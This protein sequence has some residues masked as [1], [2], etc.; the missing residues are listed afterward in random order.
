M[1]R[2]L[3]HAGLVPSSA[4]MLAL[5]AAPV[6]AGAY[7]CMD[8]SGELTYQ[9]H[10]CA[11]EALGNAIEPDIEAPGGGLGKE[12]SIEAQLRSLSRERRSSRSEKDNRKSTSDKRADASKSS[13]QDAAKC[14]KARAEAARWRGEIRKGYRNEDDKERK[15]QMLEYQEALAKRYCAPAP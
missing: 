11:G 2:S 14:A 13:G 10:P 4:L 1:K 5:V 8:P 15:A 9:G 12:T 3:A 6:A 7:K